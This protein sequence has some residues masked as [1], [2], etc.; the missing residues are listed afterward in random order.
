MIRSLL[1]LLLLAGTPVR[2]QGETSERATNR[3]NLWFPVS[4]KQSEQSQSARLGVVIKRFTALT[5]ADAAGVMPVTL[6]DAAAKKA[7]GPGNDNLS[8][9]KAMAQYGPLWGKDDATLA[10]GSVAK[11]ASRLEQ[12]PPAAVKQWLGMISADS[13][14]PGA[15]LIAGMTLVAEDE[16]FPQGTFSQPSFEAFLAK[17]K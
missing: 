5:T 4:V 13:S 8:L 3:A 12:L 17:Y 7:I 14:S 2:S 9:V 16:L 6:W 15:F 11:Y 10:A 1:L